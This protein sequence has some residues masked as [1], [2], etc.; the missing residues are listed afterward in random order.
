MVPCRPD[1]EEKSCIKCAKAFNLQRW[2]YHCMLCGDTICDDCSLFVTLSEI[3]E[4][5]DPVRREG[6]GMVAGF[7][8]SDK[9]V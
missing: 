3:C 6:R 4:S 1:Y 8:G 2:K 9:P 5:P 7:V